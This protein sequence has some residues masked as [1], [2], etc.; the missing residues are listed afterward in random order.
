MVRMGT[1]WRQDG[2]RSRGTLEAGRGW[3]LMVPGRERVRKI[4]QRQ[5]GVWENNRLL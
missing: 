5:R 2:T 1:G 4:N 3:F